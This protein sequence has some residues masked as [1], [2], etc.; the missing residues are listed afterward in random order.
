MLSK[1]PLAWQTDCSLTVTI[2]KVSMCYL[3]SQHC[4]AMLC[5]LC[6][7][8]S[9][10][11]ALKQ[12]LALTTGMNLSNDGHACPG[13]G[14]FAQT[15]TRLQARG[16]VPQVLYP[17]VQL[18]SNDAIQASQRQWQSLVSLEL[19]HFMQAGPLFVSINRFERKKV[20]YM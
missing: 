10:C 14:I 5:R 19:S 7:T 9:A 17:A 13:A 1:P 4:T 16:V 20:S 15:F 3:P 18:P 12:D 8:I 11:R 6:G 2:H